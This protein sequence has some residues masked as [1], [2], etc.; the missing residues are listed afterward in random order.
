MTAKNYEVKVVVVSSSSI[1]A[2]WHFYQFIKP[3]TGTI[4]GKV[5]ITEERLNELKSRLTTIDAVH[6][7]I[8]ALPFENVSPVT[9]I[10]IILG[11]AMGLRTSD[12]HTE[13]G[14]KKA[15]DPFP[16]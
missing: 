13:A 8:A 1:E 9:L 7:E 11:G 16:Y 14:E 3:E 4:T 2:A 10:E 6:K 15:K 5:T 12:I